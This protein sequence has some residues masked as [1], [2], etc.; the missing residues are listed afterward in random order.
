MIN[1]AG[2]YHN[3]SVNNGVDATLTIPSGVLVIDLKTVVEGDD[4]LL[5]GQTNANENGIYTCTRTGSD[6]VSTIIQRR[7]DF[8]CIEQIRPGQY[9]TVKDGAINSGSMFCITTPLPDYFGIDPLIINGAQSSLKNVTVDLTDVS[10]IGNADNF[11]LFA[12]YTGNITAPL[13]SDP[14]D[15]VGDSNTINASTIN[16]GSVAVQKNTLK[17]TGLV[18]NASNIQTASHC[19]L[20]VTNASIVQSKLAAQILTITQNLEE[21]DNDNMSVQIL[22]TYM[23]DAMGQFQSFYGDANYLFNCN[24]PDTLTYFQ[25]AG[26]TAGSAGDPAHCNAN[27]VL[28]V[29]IF[30]EEKHIP[31]FDSNA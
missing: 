10:S 14:F 31:L 18:F 7:P 22:E 28:K 9:I 5:I 11:V 26:T 29:R 20:D 6:Y 3:G 15:I 27:Y 17:I 13:D 30:G 25:P 8:Q 24:A 4:L 16:S 2:T 12:N 21:S 19:I 1:I 23:F